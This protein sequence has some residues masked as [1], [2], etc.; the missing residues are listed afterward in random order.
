MKLT[1]TNS[2]NGS[3]YWPDDLP[4]PSANP[5][6][7]EIHYLQCGCTVQETPSDAPFAFYGDV[8]SWSP[9]HSTHHHSGTSDAGTPPR[10]ASPA[11][12]DES[13]STSSEPVVRRVVD[14]GFCEKATCKRSK[15]FNRE[16][17]RLWQEHNSEMKE[18]LDDQVA[19]EVFKAKIRREAKEATE[20]LLGRM[21][22]VSA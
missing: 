18:A 13:R 10:S 20:G 7:I 8:V 2:N 5:A 4:S 21:P 1:R 17:N 22:G 14:P 12:L 15:V 6:T 11:L 9:T 16:W 19:F 3:G